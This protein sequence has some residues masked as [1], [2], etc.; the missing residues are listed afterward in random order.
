MKIADILGGSKKRKKR[1]SRLKRIRQKS[2]FDNAPIKEGGNIFP[3]SVSFDHKIIPQ[4]MKTVN[5][6][7]QKTGST[8]IPIGS[9]ATPTPGKVSGDLDMI[10]DVDQ[11]KQHFNMEDQPDKV[12][13]QKLRQVFDLAGLNTGQSGTSVHI[14]I[15]VGDNTHQV[16]I[17][18]VPN[19]DN[20]AK[21]H[22]HSIPQGSKWKGVNKQIALAN[23][24]KSKNMLWS[25]YQGLFNRDANGKKAD[26]IT[27]NIDEVARTLLGPNA[28]GKDI[29]SVEQ[30]LA[31]LGKE[32]GDA[33]LADLRN[34]PNWK[35][36]D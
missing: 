22:T 6:V 14:E 5:S 11:L 26:L 31:A 28:T 2:L 32:A 29:G 21:F 17:M 15:P 33:L 16:D 19:A 34:D 10:V 9:G 20:A 12:I 35:E 7:L 8:A 24:A 3:D 25:P 1:G 36:L 18:V 13:R 4:I 30:I 27:N 23:I